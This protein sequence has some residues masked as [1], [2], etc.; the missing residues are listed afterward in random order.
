MSRPP[1]PPMTEA[2]HELARRL[3]AEGKGYGYLA[4]EISLARGATTV[5]PATN[6]RRGVTKSWVFRA[7]RERAKTPTVPKP[8]SRTEN[9]A[10]FQNE[11]DVDPRRTI[12]Q[13]DVPGGAGTRKKT[14]EDSFA[15]PEG[16]AE[17]AQGDQDVSVQAVSG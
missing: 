11:V 2:E 14:G 10:P 16:E 3:Q 5:D 17:P 6:R 13:T 12:P 4:H 15:G 1:K 8:E 7:L 9:G